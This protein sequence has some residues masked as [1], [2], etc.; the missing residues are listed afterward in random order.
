MKIIHIVDTETWERDKDQSQYFGDTL[1]SQGFI[2][3][4]LPGQVDSVLKNWF[5]G[6][7]DLI[8]LE[9]DSNKLSTRLVF[10]NL[11]GDEEKFPHIYGPVN[12]DAILSWY[13]SKKN[14]G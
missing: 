13:P 11:E 8:F 9:I 5:P 3:C 1:K 10:E 6:R 7:E 2:H 14:Q 12:R 4:C